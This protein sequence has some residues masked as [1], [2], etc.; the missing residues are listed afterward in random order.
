MARAK[1]V[2]E[3]VAIIRAREHAE[4]MIARL[5]EVASADPPTH[6]SVKAA[7]ILLRISH[8]RTAEE[9]DPRRRFWNGSYAA[10]N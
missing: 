8:E 7:E 9:S 3:D 1:K 6:V 4:N 10:G 2:I 5:V